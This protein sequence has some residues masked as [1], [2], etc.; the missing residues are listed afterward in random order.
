MEVSRLR[1]PQ[2]WISISIVPLPS[3]IIIKQNHTLMNLSSVCQ[4]NLQNTYVLGV[5][6]SVSSTQV[7]SDPLK[8]ETYFGIGFILFMIICVSIIKIVK[9]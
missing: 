2:L 7:C 6:D 5:L 3:S 1:Y 4:T 9:M 8:M